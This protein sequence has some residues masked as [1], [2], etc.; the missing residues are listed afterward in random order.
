M[1]LAL[2]EISVQ[3]FIDLANVCDEQVTLI[4]PDPNGAIVRAAFPLLGQ[5]RLFGT[6][7]RRSGS[8]ARGLRRRAL[9][10]RVTVSS[11]W[12]GGRW[13]PPT[14]TI[15]ESMI[16]GWDQLEEGDETLQ[17]LHSDQAHLHGIPFRTTSRPRATR[18]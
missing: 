12:R 15:D 5:L 13:Q 18:G 8:A 14:F 17:H 16:Q 10:R 9:P 6:A 3:S 11:R 1:V 2:S 4:I 7:R